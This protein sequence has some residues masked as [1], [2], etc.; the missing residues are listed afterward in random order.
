MPSSFK[1]PMVV[2]GTC[3]ANGP[4]VLSVGPSYL[5]DKR[6]IKLDLPAF[7][8]PTTYTSFFLCPPR[9]RKM[10]SNSS[11][12]T[13][14]PIPAVAEA[15]KTSLALCIPN[16]FAR[17]LTNCVNLAL[18]ACAGIK[19]TLFATNTISIA[20]L[21]ACGS[22]AS[23]AS[24]GKLPSKST[25]STT[26]KTTPFFELFGYRSI[27]VP[28]DRLKSNDGSKISAFTFFGRPVFLKLKHL[29]QTIAGGFRFNRFIF[30]SAATSN[31]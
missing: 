8:A 13:L 21:S 30:F 28:T 17:R 14:M 6:L 9:L 29:A 26:T 18:V 3:D 11:L 10:S 4:P 31:S 15:N 25:K 20:P 27:C 2:P 19:S 22:N 5:L 1:T 16:A 12:K 7:C 24:T 23:T